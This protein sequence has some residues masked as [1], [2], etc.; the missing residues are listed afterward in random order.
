MSGQM[1]AATKDTVALV[2]AI[3]SRYA[4]LL[5][6]HVRL[7]GI[8]LPRPREI[9]TC[10]NTWFAVLVRFQKHDHRHSEDE[11]KAVRTFAQ[12]TLNVNGELRG[13]KATTI[14]WVD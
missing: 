6:L 1:Y 8:E 11:L 14:T 3:E 4:D 12:W 5:D 7:K 10:A 2:Q 13:Q 9:Q